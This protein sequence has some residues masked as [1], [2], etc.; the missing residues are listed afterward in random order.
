MPRQ[1]AEPGSGTAFSFSV[2][3]RTDSGF[4]AAVVCGVMVLP[5]KPDPELLPMHRPRCP[6]C[7]TRMITTAIESAGEGFER[8][9]FECRKC[10]Y[11][12]TATVASDPIEIPRRATSAALGARC[13][14]KNR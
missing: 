1:A 3:H 13:C 5:H 6:H 4:R 9:S 10:A 2:R 11:A 7:Q 8:R 14:E 12:E